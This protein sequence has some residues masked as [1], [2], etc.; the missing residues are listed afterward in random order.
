MR[1]SRIFSQTRRQAQAAAETTS[2][3]L[4]VR[5]G[6]MRQLGAGI[7]SYLP[8]GLR[9]LRGIETIL[10]EEMDAV[11][12]QEIEMPVVNPADIWKETGRFYEI[13]EE[14]TR[15]KDR[16]DRDLVLAMTHEEVVGSLVRDEI[17]SY[18][19]L[20]Q[21]IY[22]IQ[23]KWRDDPRPRAG[24]IRVREFAMKDSYSLDKDWE[25]LDRSYAAHY[26]AYLRIFARCGLPVRPVKSDTGMMGGKEAHE[27]MYEASIG[28]DTL[29]ICEVC[30]YTANRQVARFLK[31]A[32]VAED[33]RKSE[34]V[35]T[36]NVKTID[37][38]T[39]F[40]G[41]P[42]SR[43][44]KAVFMMGDFAAEDE[45]RSRLIFAV[46]RGDMDV[47]DTKLANAAGA[48]RLR[49]A[50]DEEI[51]A[52]GAVPGY[53]SPVGIKDVLLI[54]DDA[55]VSTKNLVTGANR[56]GYHT[57]NVNYGRDFTADVVTDIAV[58]GE[59]AGCPECGR[60][61]QATRGVEVGNIFKLG[62]RYSDAMG[63]SF[64]D[65]D[66]KSKT[67]IMGSY[68]I[69]VGR[70][71]ACLVEEYHDDLG[72]K[73][74]VSIAPYEVYLVDISRKTDVASQIHDSL[75]D[76]GISVLFD[77][78]EERAGVKFNDADLIGAPI[79]ITVGDRSLADGKVEMKLRAGGEEQKVPVE[80]V[81]S[82]VGEALE[83]M[84]GELLQAADEAGG[85]G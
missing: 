17:R 79:R 75:A 68:G 5:A 53:A 63:L 18:R 36:P 66:G 12:G 67:V 11:G 39:G 10:R 21:I 81:V 48:K 62:T 44:A 32:E 13:G 9:A 1:M 70:L 42:A 56:E 45:D 51:R 77:D 85:N 69:G 2:H 40:L 6:F 50:T 78:R 30:G 33:E 7:F 71:L 3:D 80:S 60:P 58:A 19:Q 15:L 26:R 76:A 73:L 24:L 57:L 72:L 74:P 37:E 52:T 38:L 61:L 41:V 25:G 84:R 59:G 23:T 55:V 65:E 47:N 8:L 43:T 16:V 83:S 28:E 4:L 82:T 14:L 22:Q 34:S 46:I 35:A 64:L 29:I 31:T 20:P 49:P 27:F 54:V